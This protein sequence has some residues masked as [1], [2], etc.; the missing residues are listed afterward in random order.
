VLR[1]PIIRVLFEHGRFGSDSTDLT[2]RALFF[3]AMGLPAFAAI[4]LIVPAFYSTKDTRTPVRVAA[5]ILVLNIVLNTLFLVSFFQTFRNG[6]PAF[7]TSLAAHVNFLALFVIFRLRFGRLGT[8][9][10]LGSSA[11]VLVGSGLMGALCW[12]ALRYSRFETYQSFLPQLV[13][14]SVVIVGATLFYLALGWLLRCPEVAEV[15]GI[16]VRRDRGEAGPP[17][18]MG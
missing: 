2:A 5:Y 11:R 13:F 7:A 10:I 18:L 17:A 16:A 3:Y 8:L 1:E 12:A 14:L 9:E 6:G 15:Y 4:K